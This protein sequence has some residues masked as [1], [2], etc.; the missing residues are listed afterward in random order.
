[1]TFRS[2]SWENIS[3]TVTVK[4]VSVPI[5]VVMVVIFQ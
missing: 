4:C 1:M 3:N 2:A 5:V